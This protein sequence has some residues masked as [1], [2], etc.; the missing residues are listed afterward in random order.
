MLGSGSVQTEVLPC[1]HGRGLAFLYSL[2][3]SFVPCSSHAASVGEIHQGVDYKSGLLV[4]MGES[5]QS[6]HVYGYVIGTLEQL[7]F[8]MIRLRAGGI[9]LDVATWANVTY[10]D[11]NN[12][13]VV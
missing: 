13:V 2:C 12:H 8:Y 1:R 4:L 9:L 11:T 10:V 3:L 6:R 7:C 5:P